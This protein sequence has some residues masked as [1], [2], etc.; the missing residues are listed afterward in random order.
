MPKNKHNRSPTSK[1]ESDKYQINYNRKNNYSRVVIE[2]LKP[3][4]G[5]WV[6]IQ[7]HQFLI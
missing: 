4:H 5:L 6:W 7:L 1:E 3:G 2:L